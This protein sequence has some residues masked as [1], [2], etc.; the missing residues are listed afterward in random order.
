M[1]AVRILAWLLVVPVVYTWLDKLTIRNRRERR[2]TA[3]AATAPSQS[4]AE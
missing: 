4:Y 1:A 3:S 2:Q